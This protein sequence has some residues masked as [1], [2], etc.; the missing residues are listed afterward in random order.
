[1]NLSKRA[2]SEEKE[3]KKLSKASDQEF[4]LRS[5]EESQNGGIHLAV[6]LKT[7]QC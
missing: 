3:G 6:G 1:M 4:H 2:L 5:L 7:R